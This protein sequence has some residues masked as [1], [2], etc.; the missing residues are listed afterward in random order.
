MT[1]NCQIGSTAFDGCTLVYIYS[2]AGSPA[3]AYCDA[4]DNC[5]FVEEAQ[6]PTAE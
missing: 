4:H 1:E 3:E 6:S 2:A 5:V